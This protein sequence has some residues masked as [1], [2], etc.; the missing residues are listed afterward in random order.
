MTIPANSRT[1]AFAW[2]ID[3]AFEEEA[4]NGYNSRLLSLL[5]ISTSGQNKVIYNLETRCFCGQQSSPSLAF[6]T[7][8]YN[9][10]TF[11]AVFSSQWPADDLFSTF[12]CSPTK[13]CPSHDAATLLALVSLTNTNSE[14]DISARTVRA[15]LTVADSCLGRGNFVEINYGQEGYCECDSDYVIKNP[16]N[17]HYARSWKAEL[18]NYGLCRQAFWPR[19][20][21]LDS[22]LSSG[23]VHH[24]T[25][26]ETCQWL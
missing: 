13:S 21:G 15:Q 1:A 11:T 7:T 12:F 8:G 16:D 22:L 25:S 19:P 23:D 6:A 24:L 9:S 2:T 5:S 14:A 26:P 18:R 20:G 4:R 3:R 17:F 10:K